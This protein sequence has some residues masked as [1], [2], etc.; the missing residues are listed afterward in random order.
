MADP[1]TKVGGKYRLEQQIARGASSSIWRAYHETLRRPVAVK[2]M[3]AGL[4]LSEERVERF[5]REAQ[6]AS[7]VQHR[8]IVDIFD[9]GQTAEGLPF[10]VM[11]LLQGISLAQRIS[12]EP[13]L[14]A[15]DFLDV[16][17]MVLSGLHGAHNAGIVHRDLKP[18]NIF[19]VEDGAG[20]YPK[21]LDFGVSFL[22]TNE[23]DQE[24]DRLT[25]EGS[26]LGTLWYMSPEQIIGQLDIDR[27]SDL[28]NI[29]VILYEA[30]AGVFPFAATTVGE[31]VVKIA[32]RTPR[33]LIEL[34][35][36]I[37]PEIA[38]LVE[39]AM[40]KD[41]E[42]R[43]ADAAEMLEAVK[44]L[45]PLPEEFTT[46]VVASART[47]SDT[48]Y[49]PSQE[50][51]LP[52]PSS[53]I[54]SLSGPGPLASGV[55]S[56]GKPSVSVAL[57]FDDSASAGLGSVPD[58]QFL[59]KALTAHGESLKAKK[60]IHPTR[61]SMFFVGL[62]AAILT[63]LAGVLIGW[64][65]GKS[66][67]SARAEGVAGAPSTETTEP[68]SPSESGQSTPASAAGELGGEATGEVVG[69]AVEEGPGGG[70]GGGPAD[71]STVGSEPPRPARRARQRRRPRRPRAREE[72]P[73]IFRDPGF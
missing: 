31:L 22:A 1:G 19:L 26:I 45:P 64:W 55:G 25:Q 39:R 41:R 10:M 56:G 66:T 16:I 36:N 15:Q 18:E 68:T 59:T 12:R 54:S 3:E 7:L 67:Q 63:V 50:G 30:F 24:V 73:S 4:G 69:D 70:P 48:Q 27:R 32:T 62:G 43:F 29:G 2:I 53:S 42:Q 6:L 35:P 51:G 5:L 71:G 28:Y 49:R 23:L 13:A 52:P 60:R 65:G 61:R 57:S 72:A 33:P 9:I 46:A 17:A 38:A 37:P 11:E 20:S 40:A 8:Y 34:R 14:P 47:S 21:I 44:A 58:G